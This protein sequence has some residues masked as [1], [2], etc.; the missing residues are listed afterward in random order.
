MRMSN[1]LELARFYQV[2]AYLKIEQH[3]IEALAA[4]FIE[5]DSVCRKLS[6]NAR[7][8]FTKIVCLYCMRENIETA[9]AIVNDAGTPMNTVK[10]L[11]KHFAPFTDE[12][13]SLRNAALSEYLLLKSGISRNLASSAAG[14]TPLF[15]RNS[16][17]RL[18]KNRFDNW[19]NT[20]YPSG[21]PAS[22]RLSVWPDIYPFDEFDPLQKRVLLSLVY[23]C[24]NPLGAVGMRAVGF[25]RGAGSER[26]TNISVQ[27][28]LLQIV[29][30]KRLG[31]DCSLKARAYGDE[32]VVDIE[33]RKILSPGPDGKTDTKDDIT[34]PIN[35]ELLGW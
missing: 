28:D 22:G 14:K 12:H 21:G 33:N 34:L 31:K 9:N 13:V 23:R 30:K 2:Y 25:S 3:D 7:V 15:K 19:L 10:L 26:S 6:V 32:Y 4:D 27:D 5:L 24:Y 1:L 18:Y 8:L 16:T 29:L 20:Q 17:L 35:L 11:A